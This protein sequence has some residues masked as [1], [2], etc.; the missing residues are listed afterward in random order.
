MDSAWFSR[1]CALF[2]EQED[3]SCP[4]WSSAPR[5][6]LGA[7]QNAPLGSRPGQILCSCGSLCLGANT[8]PALVL[9]AQCPQGLQRSAAPKAPRGHIQPWELPPL[10]SGHSSPSAPP[11]CSVLSAE[12]GQCLTSPMSSAIPSSQTGSDS[13][14]SLLLSSPKVFLSSCQSCCSSWQFPARS[15]TEKAPELWHLKCLGVF[16]SCL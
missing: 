10:C 12:Q 6:P 9:S 11:S 8:T 1:V 15:F 2:P 4:R 5:Q 7:S 16:S 13:I 14:P 3:S